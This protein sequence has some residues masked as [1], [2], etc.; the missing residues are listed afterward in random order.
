MKTVINIFTSKP[1]SF[2]ETSTIKEFLKQIALQYSDFK[3]LAKQY[4]LRFV[5]LITRIW[6]IERIEH[7]VESLMP[8]IVNFI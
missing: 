6:N 5:Y 2:E 1:E 4:S 7:Y 3:V 8:L